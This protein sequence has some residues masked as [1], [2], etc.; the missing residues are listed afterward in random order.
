MSAD[1][2]KK[3]EFPIESKSKEINTMVQQTM[4]AISQMG[5]QAVDVISY[6]YKSSVVKNIGEMV[7]KTQRF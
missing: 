6:I 5:S 1:Y 2:E 3:D 4:N 7:I